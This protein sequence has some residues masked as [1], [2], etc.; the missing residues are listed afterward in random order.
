MDAKVQRLFA[1]GKAFTQYNGGLQQR[2]QL[3]AGPKS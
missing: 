3:P 2:D 1:V